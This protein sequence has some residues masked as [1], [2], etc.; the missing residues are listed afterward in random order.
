[1]LLLKR[2][3]SPI[4]LR[5]KLWFGGQVLIGIEK[6]TQVQKKIKYRCVCQRFIQGRKKDPR[7]KEF[8]SCAL[9]WLCPL[10][11]QSLHCPVMAFPAGTMVCFCRAGFL[12][13][14][15]CL[16]RRSICILAVFTWWGKW[17]QNKQETGFPWCFLLFQTQ[18]GT[19]M[20]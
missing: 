2:L 10:T 19:S 16:E 8:L 18:L 13:I 5:F 11:P 9:T 20:T 3:P 15:L 12:C 4:Q 14:S 17:Y 1:M 6:K 7:P